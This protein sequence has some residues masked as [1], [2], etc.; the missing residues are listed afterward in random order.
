MTKTSSIY[1]GFTTT[2]QL[3]IQPKPWFSQHRFARRWATVWARIAIAVGLVIGSVTPSSA[4]WWSGRDEIV[5]GR[6]TIIDGDTLEISGERIRLEGIDAPEIAQTCKNAIG[7]DWPCGKVSAERLR[8]LTRG[9]DIRCRA[10]GKDKYGRMLAYCY[11][12]PI[13]LNA[14]LV[15]EGLA[16]AFVKYS[17]VFEDIEKDARAQLVGVWQGEAMAPWDYRSGSWRFAEQKAPNGCAIK[18][19]ISGRNRIYHMPWS[20]WYSKVRID[21]DSGE[22]WFCSEDEASAAGWRPVRAGS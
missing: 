14:E 11:R 19:N 17:N 8:E 18:G 6:A 13:D 9:V 22:R 4:N 3:S 15:R 12:G 5:S 1:S 20:P 16:W 21:L 10:T 2:L 7:R